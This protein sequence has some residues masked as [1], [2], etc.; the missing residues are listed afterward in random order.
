[1]LI[2]LYVAAFCHAALALLLWFNRAR[3]PR[4][5][6][7]KGPRELPK[8]V[9]VIVPA[10]NEE[11]NI[12]QCVRSILNQDYPSLSVRV[13]DDHST[14]RTGAI[15]GKLA[16]YDRRLTVVNPPAL[17][18]GWLGK[19]HAVHNGS[20]GTMAD[21]LLFIDADVRLLPTAVSRAIALAEAQ[22][23]G[24]TTV[25]PELVADSFWERATQPLIGLLLFGLL[26]PVRVNDPRRDEAVGFG[27]FMLFR[28]DAYEQLG[29]HQAVQAE[30][31]ED[32]KLAQLVKQKRLGLCV[33]H[34]TDVVKLR[35]YDSLPAMIAGWTKNFHV[36]L[37]PLKALAP[38]FALLLAAVFTLPTVMFWLS[39]LWLAVLGHLPHF[40][41]AAT[42]AYGA[43]WLA[44][45]SLTSAY[46]VTP[47]GVRAV[48]GLVVGYIL[49][50]SVYRAAFGRPVTWRGRSVQAQ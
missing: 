9:L 24:L 48:G 45:L 40:A 32:L 8:S 17:P 15:V 23:A 6:Q 2:V 49:C 11:T 3:T 37:G 10:R 21:Y 30:V 42:L 33:A 39:L 43:D 13:V 35:M 27:P 16:E 47:R 18:A 5:P 20:L 25:M 36:A 22:G 26:D 28:R 19:P 31:I 7:V 38:L 12:G 50:S 29:G 44:R 41:I 4:L 34:G 14:D 46:D 1:M